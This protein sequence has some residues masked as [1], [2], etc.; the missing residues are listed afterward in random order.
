[1]SCE[2]E[3]TGDAGAHG[4]SSEKKYQVFVS[5]TYAD[6]QD[7][8]QEL[9]LNLL[10]LGLIPA[11]MELYP[12]EHNNQWPVIQ[13]VIGE[14]DYYIVVVGGRYGTLSPMGLSYTHREFTYAVTKGK[15]V[16]A[17]I[18]EAPDTLPPHCRE[19][20][21]EG[22]VRLH[23]FRKQLQEKS[24]WF[25]WR[26][27]ADLVQALRVSLPKFIR[28]HPATGWVRAGQ[29]VTDLDQ[30]R[31]LQALRKRVAELEREREEL[32]VGRRPAIDTLAR[33]SDPAVLTYSCNVYVKGDCKVTT[34]ECRV[35]WDDVVT[36]VGPRLMNEAPENVIREAIEEMIAGRA[37]TDVQQTVPK[38]HAV[39][40]V[41]LSTQSFNQIKIHL[42]A[43]G[44][45]RKSSRNENTGQT[46]WQLTAHG[47]QTMT[48]LLAVRS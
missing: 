17:F 12:T 20:T 13:K 42:R 45:I 48:G 21:R 2:H 28:Q 1:M 33:G 29:S 35:T 11:G 22:E 46:W 6:L 32:V 9:M 27:P 30:A 5:S 43:L 31:E 4:V 23:D 47:D 26:T 18:H 38:A 3:A 10:T 36:T 24:T 14:C 34:A 41:V 37:L 19:G 25:G 44:L 16:I 15:P 7:V 8:R 39:R 40:N